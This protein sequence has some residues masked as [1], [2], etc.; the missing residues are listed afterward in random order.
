MKKKILLSIIPALLVLSSCSGLGPKEEVKKENLFAEDTLA[1]EEIFGDAEIEMQEYKSPLKA[2]MGPVAPVY[3]VQY[4]D[5]EEDGKVHM[6]FIAAIYLPNTSINVSWS[7]TMYKGHGNGDQSGHV[8]KA[9]SEIG[10]SKAYTSLANGAENPLT[11]ADINANYGAGDDYNYFVVYTMLNIPKETYADYSIRANLVMSGLAYGNG[12]AATVDGS[13]NATFS[14]DTT[15][16]F[17]SGRFDGVHAEFA[18]E[19]DEGAGKVQ[20]SDNAVYYDLPLLPGDTLALVYFD[21]VNNV[22]LL[23]GTSRFI[24]AS[25][26]YFNNSKKTMTTQFAGTYTIYLNSSDQIHTTASGVIRP[27]YV[28]VP[29]WLYGD[30][31]WPALYAFGPGDVQEW[32]NIDTTGSHGVVVDNENHPK[33]FDP[34]IYTGVIIVRMAFGK[35]LDDKWDGKFYN[36]S[37][38][39]TFPSA[40]NYDGYSQKVQDCI[41]SDLNGSWTGR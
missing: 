41:H 11:I 15:G 18:P 35:T 26:Y 34:A 39:T 40:P 5:S 17:I 8:Y 29:S 16:H 37:A 13:A 20:G 9:E 1:H 32:Y 31:A 7:R 28:D 25:G 3:G 33:L 2:P 36:Q 23:N 14:M 27:I 4:Q 21:S 12:I 22:F 24:N 30:S 38:D 6:R 19:Y 10:C